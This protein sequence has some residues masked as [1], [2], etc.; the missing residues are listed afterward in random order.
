[1][2]RN[3]KNIMKNH[4][5]EYANEFSYL[6]LRINYINNTSSYIQ[7]RFLSNNQF[8]NT[9]SKLMKLEALNKSLKLI[10]YISTIRL[11]VTCIKLDWLLIKK[12]KQT[13]Y[14]YRKY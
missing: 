3:N 13:E 2:Y 4:E 10:I 6:G 8:D 9:Y 7:A 1:M 11:V 14:F 12:K 5:F